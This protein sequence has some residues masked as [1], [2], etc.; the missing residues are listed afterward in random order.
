MFYF[1]ACDARIA[2]EGV[3]T[4]EQILASSEKHRLNT[5][6]V[7][8]VYFWVGWL[9]FSNGLDAEMQPLNSEN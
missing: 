1:S 7:L 4:I 3:L 6:F 2:E 5:T 8:F 9:L